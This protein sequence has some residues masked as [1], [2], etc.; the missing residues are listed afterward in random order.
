MALLMVV[1]A[2]AAAL[3]VAGLAPAACD[4]ACERQTASRLIEEGASRAAIDRVKAARERFPDDR[5]LVLLLARAYLREGNLFWAERTLADAAARWPDDAELR[6]WLAAVHLRQGDPEL[7]GEDLAA[8]LEPDG[9]PLAARWRLLEASRAR[10]TG[11]AEAA[12]TRLEEAADADALY[13]EDR[14]ALAALRRDLEPWWSPALGGTFDLGG[15]HTSNALAGSPTDPGAPGDPSGLVLAELRG[16]VAPPLGGAVA[17]FLDLEVLGDGLTRD[18]YR[19]LSSLEASLRLGGAVAAGDH[20]TSVG[21]RAEVLELDQEPSRFSDAH[22]LEVEVEWLSGHVLFGG[23]GHRRYRDAR[24]TRWETDVG[25]GGPLRL[26]PG[27]P[28]VAGAT[29]RRADADSPAYDLV[30]VS[31]AASAAIPLG[32]GASLRLSL[33]A[34]WDD[35][36][37]SG[38]AEGLAV[39][40]TTDTRRDLL[41]RVGATLWAPAWRGLRPGLELRASRRDSTAD[42]RPGFDF[43]YSEWRAVLWLRVTFDADPWAPPTVAP[44]GHVPLEWGL[45]GDRGLDQERILD[46]LRRD[47]ELRRGSSCTLP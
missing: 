18:A 23:A 15:G 2:V 28:T 17:P 7:A 14:P 43:S 3:V 22:R 44:P 37:N 24:R 9:G 4:V 10:L 35:Y 41:G 38:G 5:A 39:F 20:R 30:G 19:E 46:L 36:L 32:R 16:R 8:D 40:G 6:A 1:L 12:R 21:Y 11:D 47:E 33:S 42:D 25:V 29:L 13:P 34:A 27:W 31:A 45:A 26:R